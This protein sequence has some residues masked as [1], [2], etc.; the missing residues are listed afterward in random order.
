MLG[1]QGWKLQRVRSLGSLPSD[2]A[3]LA[4][5][6]RW[7]GA[8]NF[9]PLFTMGFRVCYPKR[10]GALCIPKTLPTLA[11]AFE[12]GGAPHYL[13]WKQNF[14]VLGFLC[15]VVVFRI[16]FT[17]LEDYRKTLEVSISIY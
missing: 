4:Q 8:F 7:P 17:D 14:S 13:P 6:A 11:D 2:E 5:A 15:A 16:R 1:G 10:K 3:L 12:S 9:P